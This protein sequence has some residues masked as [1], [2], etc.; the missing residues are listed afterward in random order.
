MPSH[1]TARAGR[2]ARSGR[3]EGTREAILTVAERM[4]A[5][6]GV[7]AVSNRQISEAAGQGNNAAVGYHFGTKTDLLRA[8]V[9]KHAAHI[10][11]LRREMPAETGDSLD[12][13]DW[14]ARLVRPSTDHLAE[15]GSPTWFARF[16]TQMMTDPVL[17]EVM[18]EETF[19]PPVQQ[20]L[21][22]LNRCIPDLPLPVRIERGEMARHLLM[23]MLAERERALTENT[24]TTRST[25]PEY[26]DGL[27]DAITGIR[28]APVTPRP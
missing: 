15:L 7:F 9:R 5:E 4:F 26:A 19:G 6:H 21:D 16:A 23:H 24:H 8:I 13:R 2:T 28:R 25:W 1:R 22:G 20:T 18:T 12:V 17:R 14:V 11:E 27:I 10:E 3:A